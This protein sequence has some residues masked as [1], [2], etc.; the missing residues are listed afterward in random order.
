MITNKV[1]NSK[2]EIP[3]RTTLSPVNL[4]KIYDV[5][6]QKTKEQL[7]FSSTYPTITYDTWSD[8]YRH[9]SYICFTTHFL[10]SRLQ[11]QTYTWKTKPI[12]E[13]HTGEPIKTL[14]N[15]HERV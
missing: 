7:K 5:C 15:G 11:L 13:S 4:N 8:K 9:R 10:G 14:F 12:V 1:V 2:H 3:S 6:V